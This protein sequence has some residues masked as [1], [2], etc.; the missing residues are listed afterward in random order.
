V[1]LRSIERRKACARVLIFIIRASAVALV[2]AMGVYQFPYGHQLTLDD[3]FPG[4]RTNRH[5]RISLALEPSASDGK[6]HEATIEAKA[7]PV[8]DAAPAEKAV[9]PSSIVVPETSTAAPPSGG[10]V[11]CAPDRSQDN[12]E[13]MGPG[14]PST[15]GFARLSTANHE[16]QLSVLNRAR[17]EGALSGY[18]VNLAPSRPRPT[19]LPNLYGSL[20]GSGEEDFAMTV[21]HGSVDFLAV[22]ENDFAAELNPWYHGLNAGFRPQIMSKKSCEL[23]FQRIR[24][25]TS[26][27]AQTET[28]SGL[29]RK[30]RSGAIY[31]SDGHVAISDFRVNG[32]KPA[33]EVGSEVRLADPGNVSV[34]ASVA[35]ILN[36]PKSATT[37]FSGWN[38]ERSRIP[39]SQSI[40]IEIVVN[41]RA[42]ASKP[43]LA[44]GVEQQLAFNAFIPNSSWIALRAMGAAHTNPVF[45]LVNNEPVRASRASVEWSMRAVVEAYQVMS[46]NRLSDDASGARAAYAYAYAVYQRILDETRMP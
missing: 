8:V 2:S 46:A 20:I 14:S 26:Y 5:V 23:A 36:P 22:G 29:R 15:S 34:T 40:M 9:S 12:L 19:L 18:Q 1:A 17:A 28:M 13:I 37:D 41:G 25:N 43:L 11:A 3:L 35:A 44:N 31:V 24:S 16:F 33:P 45:V 39:D 30:M 38:V 4:L 32:Q 6:S 10:I 7:E 42:V 21:A 27:A